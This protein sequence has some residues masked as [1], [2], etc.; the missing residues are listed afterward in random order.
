M[1]YSAQRKWMQFR[2]SFYSV[3]VMYARVHAQLCLTLCDSM[4]CSLSGSFV[5]GIFH[6]RILEWVAI[7]FS[8]GS[9]WPRDQTH[10][11]CIGRQILYHW[12]TWRSALLWQYPL[13]S[14]CRYMKPNWNFWKISCITL[15]FNCKTESKLAISQEPLFSI[16]TVLTSRR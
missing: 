11:S 6:A 9:F 5:H 12:V 13:K 1:V 3:T 14:L 15:K 8:R 4:D 16:G 10:I 2:N 7:S